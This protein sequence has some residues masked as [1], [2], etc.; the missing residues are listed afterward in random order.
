V[1]DL[2]QR[3]E[4]LDEQLGGDGPRPIQGA[5]ADALEEM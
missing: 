2:I 1:A 5:V 4:A 3:L